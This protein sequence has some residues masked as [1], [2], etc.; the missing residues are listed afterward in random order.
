MYMG[1][2]STMTAAIG[3]KIRY[4]RK[5]KR[6]FVLRGDERVVEFTKVQ[7]DERG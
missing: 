6:I 7:E 5:G 4:C 1:S 2:S 3:Q